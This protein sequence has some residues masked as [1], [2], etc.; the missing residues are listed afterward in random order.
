MGDITGYIDGAQLALYV[1]FAFFA[2]LIFWLR[3]EDR[4]EGYPLESDP[5]GLRRKP[6][7]LL[8]PRRKTYLLRD[9]STYSTPNLAGDQ[10]P[11]AAR[12]A[13]PWPGAPLIPT[14]DPLVDGVGPAAWAER[15]D[16]PDKTWDGKNR[17][18]PAGT[19]GHYDVA[20]RDPDP[21]GLPVIAADG[22]V[23]GTVSDI[24]ID[25]AE[26]IVRY[27]QLGEASLAD[28]ALLIPMTLAR[29]VRGRTGRGRIGTASIKVKSITSAQF[30]NV[31]RTKSPDAVTSLEEDRVMAYFVGGQLYATPARAE[32]LL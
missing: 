14:G 21:R 9:G 20:S 8:Y 3:R 1:F 29:F 11:V 16:V 13:A 7:V 31:P 18:T 19:N 30:A 2:G 23:I 32:P 5:T 12:R 17:I 6:G 10:R 26:H 4:R 27:L 25:R 22:Q 15:R 24:W 28:G